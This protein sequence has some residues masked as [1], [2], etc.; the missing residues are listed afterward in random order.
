MYLTGHYAVAIVMEDFNDST[1]AVKYHSVVLQFTFTIKGLLI[2][3]VVKCHH[4]T[5]RARNRTVLKD[6]CPLNSRDCS[7][8]LA[9]EG[10]EDICEGIPKFC[11]LKEKG[12]KK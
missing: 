4:P 5:K 3:F 11:L 9:G 7:L 1:L 12:V 10:V 8:L 6:Y 2:H